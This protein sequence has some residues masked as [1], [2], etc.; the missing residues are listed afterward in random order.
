MGKVPDPRI[1]QMTLIPI[2]QV[3]GR[4]RAE[5]LPSG[6]QR[7]P[8]W[9]KVHVQ[10]GARFK[11]IRETLKTQGLHTIC[12]EA[13]CPNIW[14]CWNNQTATFL[15]LGDICTR[16]CH[17][18]S[19]TTGRPDTLDAE[20]PER[21]AF[22]VKALGLR[23]AVI[24]SVN[25]DEL[26]DGGA[27]IFS[28]TIRAI[29]RVLPTCTVEVLVPDFQGREDSVDTV[30]MANPD[31]F[32]HNIETVPRLFPSIRPQGKYD[33]SLQVLRWAKQRR[34]RTKSG[35]MVGMGETSEEVG[36][37]LNDLRGVGCDMVSIGQ[38]LQP[39]KQH[40]PVMQ[41]YTP[42]EFHTFKQ[43]GLAMGFRHVE[44]GPLVRSSYHAEQ[45]AS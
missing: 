2:E 5:V 32:N 29:R 28:E 30:L 7:L 27:R 41:Y 33:R 35:L 16:R 15:I 13:R 11:K 6:R 44:S 1:D 22:A 37:V 9:F 10:Q 34:A 42:E 43:Q 19:V 39:T 18:C 40:H 26:E 36:K 45:Q 23:H 3:K 12:E 21:V 4:S 20:E 38:Y 25:R 31:I 17:Y 24:T 14:E 8:S